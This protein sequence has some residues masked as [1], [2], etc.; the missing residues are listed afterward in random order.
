MTREKTKKYEEKNVGGGKKKIKGRRH[1]FWM[2]ITSR[3]EFLPSSRTHVTKACAYIYIYIYPTGWVSA[4]TCNVSSV[5]GWVRI[6]KPTGPCEVVLSRRWGVGA[7]CCVTDLDP[8]RACLGHRLKHPRQRRSPA[9]SP[10]PPVSATQEQK[11]VV[12]Y[13]PCSSPFFTELILHVAG[14]ILTNQDPAPGCKSR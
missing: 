3:T 11:K 8:R 4:S 7:A 14:K 12:L 13:A 1:I 6:K 2:T 10:T 5:G 9:L